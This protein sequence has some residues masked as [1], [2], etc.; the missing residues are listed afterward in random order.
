DDPFF[1]RLETRALC[2]EGYQVLQ[3]D[4]PTE[5]LRLAGVTSTIDLLLTDFVMPELNGLELAREFRTLHPEV[6]VLMVS[7]SLPMVYS[8]AGD[9]D[10]F[11][12][13]E[14]SFVFDALLKKVHALLADVAPLP[15]SFY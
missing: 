15:A 1:L 10:R 13:L 4:G 6:P 8:S 3:A 12:L 7:S 14:K 5:A 11:S 2:A 9:L